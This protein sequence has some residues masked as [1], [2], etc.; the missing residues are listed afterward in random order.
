VRSDQD[1]QHLAHMGN[2]CG[3]STNT[4]DNTWLPDSSL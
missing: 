1:G 4:S 2:I 3:V